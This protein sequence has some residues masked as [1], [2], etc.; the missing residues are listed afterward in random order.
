[1]PVAHPPKV[2]LVGWDAADWKVI[3]PLVAL[4]KMPTVAALLVEGAHGNLATLL[5]PLSPMLWTS[6]ATGQRPYKHGIHGF[7]EPMPNGQGV[8]PIT[9]LSRKVKAFWNVLNQNGHRC[10]VV[11]WWPSN[12]PEPLAGAMISDHY[13]RADV[14]PGKPWPLRPGLVH[15]PSLAEKLAP[16]RLHPSEL[17]EEHLLPFVPRAAEIDQAKDSRLIMLAKNL[18]DCTNVHAAATYLLQHEPADCTA[19]YFDAIDHFSH[20]FMRYHPPR[21]PWVSEKDFELFH[22]VIEGAYRYHDMMLGVLLEM[23]GPDC[24]VLLMSDHG[25]HSDTLRPALLPAEAAGPAEEHRRYGIFAA[26]GPG[27]KRGGSV[28]GASVLDLAPTILHLFGLPVGED[29]DG[30]VLVE[31]FAAPSEPRFIPTWETV[32]GPQPDGRHPPDTRVDPGD[33][34]AALEQLVALGYIEPPPDDAARAVQGCLDEL[35]YNLARS[36]MD[37]GLHLHAVPLLEDLAGRLVDET[38]HG[39]LLTRSLLALGRNREAREVFER[40]VAHKREVAAAARGELE[41]LH[42]EGFTPPPAETPEGKAALLRLRTLHAKA[43][44]HEGL[45]HL[46]RATICLAAGENDAALREIE[47][48]QTPGT[49]RNAGV[50]LQ[51]GEILLSLARLEAAEAAFRRV[52]EIDGEHAEAHYGLARVHLK[53]RRAHPAANEALSAVELQPF[54]P[55]AHFVLAVALLRLRQP[56]PA[57]D[58]LR[59]CLR[60]NPNHVPARLRLA[61]VLER[62]GHPA[63]AAEERALALAARK[64]VRQMRTARGLPPLPAAAMVDEAVKNFAATAERPAE[65]SPAPAASDLANVITIVS[66]LPRSG[67]SLVMQM[68]AA[69]GV[70]LFA[71]GARVADAAN[72]RG[73]HEHAK[74]MGL[75]RDAAWLGEACGHAV[76][77]VAPLLPFL[78]PGQTY[79]V[80]FVERDLEEVLASQT[81]MLAVQGR[82]AGDPAVLRRAYRQQN[83]AALG[84]LARQPHLAHLVVRHA[85][86]L[87]APA[88][89][90]AQLNAFLG[91]SLDVARM[92]GAVDPALHRQ[93]R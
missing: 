17:G 30:R 32:Q 27:I 40:A 39:L 26:R 77:I 59:V 18:A 64:R 81:A 38:R 10:N 19:I 15:P 71:D 12:P 9:V 75:A 11:G 6:I 79:R 7:T 84:L 29:L 74:V 46:I 72:P 50:Q 4:G 34:R 54:F 93:R 69:G 67:T 3:R 22:G 23:V 48:A 52:L 44:L 5:P 88:K 82:P 49:A 31:I 87:T 37:G 45:V 55:A 60:Q 86:L 16:L 66:G 83:A 36:Y 91:G 47:L 58:A 1:M 61:K 33:G 78:P 2:L 70:K 41:K 80:I 25:F 53:Q 89:S 21:L 65:L 92:A 63:R 42:A 68:L 35:N 13:H 8:R 56:Q 85:D 73:Y 28:V 14:E 43:G 90:A 20:G 24:T 51:L 57:V 76:K 62:L